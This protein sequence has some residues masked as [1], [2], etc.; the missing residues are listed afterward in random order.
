MTSPVARIVTARAAGFRM[1]MLISYGSNAFRNGM[2][3]REDVRR[4]CSPFV[5]K[6]RLGRASL[7]PFRQRVQSIA[8]PAQ[9]S[10][11]GAAVPVSDHRLVIGG[12]FVWRAHRPVSKI[13]KH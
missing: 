4:R 8:L 6:R 5:W 10:D 12:L 7:Q 13:C 2:A 1:N 9:A 3:A 11:Q